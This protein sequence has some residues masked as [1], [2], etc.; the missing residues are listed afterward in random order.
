MAASHSLL[1]AP[2]LGRRIEISCC[3]TGLPSRA[4]GQPTYKINYA[5]FLLSYRM[6]GISSTFSDGGCDTARPSEYL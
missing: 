3:F 6:C 1:L 4:P 5:D 2:L